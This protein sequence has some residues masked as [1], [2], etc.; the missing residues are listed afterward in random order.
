ML[1]I[2]S[3]NG[4]RRTAI[5]YNLKKEKLNS[6][7]CQ[8]FFGCFIDISPIIFKKNE[9]MDFVLFLTMTTEFYETGC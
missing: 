9:D 3:A 7:S 4:D 6:V 8:L 5:V 2:L 1:I